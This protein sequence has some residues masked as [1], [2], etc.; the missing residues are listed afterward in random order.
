MASSTGRGA[1]R[2]AARWPVVW[3]TVASADAHCDKRVSMSSSG[4]AP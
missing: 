1:E 3:G 2:Q 4:S